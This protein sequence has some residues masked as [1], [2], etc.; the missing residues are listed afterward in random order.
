MHN[1]HSQWSF[2]HMQMVND[3][4]ESVSFIFT[5]GSFKFLLKRLI[6]RM[7]SLWLLWTPLCSLSSVFSR[8]ANRVTGKWKYLNIKFHYKHHI[9][10]YFVLWKHNYSEFCS[11]WQRRFCSRNDEI[12]SSSHTFVSPL[13][14]CHVL[15]FMKKKQVEPPSHRQVTLPFF[16]SRWTPLENTEKKTHQCARQSSI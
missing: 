1:A 4:L 16:P 8:H 15:L 12:Q 3:H 9:T 14:R 5:I 11:Y 6:I 10:S 7:G 13:L 2:C